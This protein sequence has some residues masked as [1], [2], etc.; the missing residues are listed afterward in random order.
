MMVCTMTDTCLN[1]I[2]TPASSTTKTGRHNIA[3]IFLKVALNTIKQTN[4]LNAY[5][6]DMSVIMHTIKTCVSHS[7]D[8]HDM[9]VMMYAVNKYQF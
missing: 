2:G 9:S 1:C 4:N 6:Q 5:H 7:A 3:E 8:H